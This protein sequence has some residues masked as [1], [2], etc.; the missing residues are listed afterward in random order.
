[1]LL[2]GDVGRPIFDLVSYFPK[3]WASTLPLAGSDVVANHYQLVTTKE[4]VFLER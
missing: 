3:I 2:V 1:V 4:P